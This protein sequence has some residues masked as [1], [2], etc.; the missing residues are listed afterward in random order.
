[1]S[2]TTVLPL[3]RG[4]LAMKVL[5]FVLMCVAAALVMLTVCNVHPFL[6]RT[7]ARRI[8]FLGF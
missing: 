3:V 1:M 4:G 2:M 8:R 5:A 6:I 7:N